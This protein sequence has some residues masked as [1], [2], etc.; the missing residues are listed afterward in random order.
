MNNNTRLRFIAAQRKAKFDRCP[1]LQGQRVDSPAKYHLRGL[2][3]IG[4]DHDPERRSLR[5][6]SHVTP[7]TGRLCQ[8]FVDHLPF[9]HPV[10]YG[11]E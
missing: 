8:R 9:D 7:G 5:A 4:R 1:L 2:D 6:I 3:D 10:P 11:A